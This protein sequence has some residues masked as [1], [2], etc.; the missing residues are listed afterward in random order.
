MSG[1]SMSFAEYVHPFADSRLLLRIF[2]QRSYHVSY[3]KYVQSKIHKWQT[4]CTCRN[5]AIYSRPM[6]EPHD[7]GVKRNLV[8][9]DTSPANHAQLEAPW[10][11]ARAIRRR[12]FCPAGCSTEISCVLVIRRLIMQCLSDRVHHRAPRQLR[13]RRGHGTTLPFF[14]L[15]S[16]PSRGQSAC[17][18]GPLGAGHKPKLF[19]QDVAACRSF[20]GDSASDLG[21]CDI[22][23]T[24]EAT[25]KVGGSDLCQG[26]QSSV[27]HTG[28]PVL[29]GKAWQGQEN[30]SRTYDP[31]V[32]PEESEAKQTMNHHQSVTPLLQAG[33]EHLQGTLVA[34]SHNSTA[35]NRPQALCLLEGAPTLLLSK[36]SANSPG[37]SSA[38]LIKLLM[39][40]LALDL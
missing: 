10:P 24:P 20:Q 33:N 35:S 34:S 21:R 18:S 13:A 37:E 19:A 40:Q 4:K 23:L 14:G 2:G 30:G 17:A 32:G 1:R 9:I 36:T 16:G 3:T 6:T 15:H 22:D 39:P 29:R 27:A 26:L 7:T 31:T 38:Q 8:V 25:A 5:L 28:W 11:Q 12:A